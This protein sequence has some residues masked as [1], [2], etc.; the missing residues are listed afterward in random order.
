MQY[1]HVVILSE[2]GESEVRQVTEVLCSD[3]PDRSADCS[4]SAYGIGGNA[5][6][7]HRKNTFGPQ[8]R[9]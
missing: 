5:P 7:S 4:G 2:G 1:A 3:I 6:E 9:H 8:K